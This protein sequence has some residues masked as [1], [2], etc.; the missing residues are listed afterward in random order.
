MPRFSSYSL[1]RLSTCDIRLQD[2]FLRVVENFDCKVTCGH[3][4]EE[5][6]NKAYSEGRSKVEWPNSKHNGTPSQAVDI[7]PYPINYSDT[8]RF[9]YFAGFVLGTA[10]AMG[11]KIRWGGDWDQ[12]T[13][14]LD[15]KFN[16][17]MHFELVP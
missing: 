15:N 4:T 14:V 3:R 9:C 5:A 17:L 12:D 13:E 8:R 1:E 7:A 10:Q 16:D 2:L 11:I 6:Q